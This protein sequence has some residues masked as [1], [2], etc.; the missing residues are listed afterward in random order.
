M[1]VLDSPASP[2]VNASAKNKIRVVPF[3]RNALL[4]LLWLWLYRAVFD[5]LAIIFTRED[6]R[7]NQLALVGVI[8]LFAIQFRREQARPQLDASPQ[9]NLVPLMFVIGGSLGYLLVERFLD[10]NTI[11]ASLFGLA[12]YGLLG[13]WMN[14]QHWR[15]GLPAALLVI[16]VLPFGEHMQTFIGYPMRILTASLVRDGLAS[17]GVAS[18]GVD[19]ILILE[20][21]VSQVDLPCS[22]VKSLW[23]GALFLLAA[24]W[25]ERRPLTARWFVVA[26][27]FAIILFATNLARVATLVVVGQVLGSQL[28]AEMLHVPLGVLGFVAGCATAVVLLRWLQPNNTWTQND[29]DERRKK[30]N[31]PP[32]AFIRPPHI[33]FC[34]RNDVP[35]AGIPVHTATA[36]WVDAIAARVEFSG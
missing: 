9:P 24:T 27:A 2:S 36:N 20:N 1:T 21:G 26:L 16:G 12:S 13:L 11:S 34:A 32:S 22:G 28:A 17:A 33:L 23:T 10:I 25:V 6:F 3:A 4:M 19:T 29:A 30:E 31:P 8:V 35:R 5:Y 14:S 7:T 18:I 15:A